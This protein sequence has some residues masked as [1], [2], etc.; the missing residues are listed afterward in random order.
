MDSLTIL[1]RDIL[2]TEDIL[3]RH[4]PE[5]HPAWEVISAALSIERANLQIEYA[6]KIIHSEDIPVPHEDEWAV[7][8]E[9]YHQ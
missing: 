3:R 9:E 4:I 8:F 5:G 6:R 1:A 2:H 7:T